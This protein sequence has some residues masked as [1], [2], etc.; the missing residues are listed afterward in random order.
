MN[1]E[2]NGNWFIFAENKYT[3][4]NISIRGKYLVSFCE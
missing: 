4:D 1:L 2:K 3:N